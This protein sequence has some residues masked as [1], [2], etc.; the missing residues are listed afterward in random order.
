MNEEELLAANPLFV[1]SGALLVSHNGFVN[2]FEP[3][4]RQVISTT[5]AAPHREL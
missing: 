1:Q 5:P 3:A 2:F 4:G